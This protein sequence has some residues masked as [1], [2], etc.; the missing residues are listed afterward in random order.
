MCGVKAVI[1]TQSEY[2]SGSSKEQTNDARL[3]RDRR[4]ASSDLFCGDLPMHLWCDPTQTYVHPANLHFA[5]IAFT[6]QRQY[7][8]PLRQ[9]TRAAAA[10]GGVLAG[11]D[12]FV[13]EAATTG[14]K[15]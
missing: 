3:R 13:G 12:P 7:R 2:P 11:E 5:L 10:V 1:Q 4:M 8:P 9:N 14:D 15:H 6:A